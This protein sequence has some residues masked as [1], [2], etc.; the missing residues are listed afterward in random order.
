MEV[1]WKS[2]VE[3]CRTESDSREWLGDYRLGF[4]INGE[5]EWRV[6][7]MRPMHMQTD[8]RIHDVKHKIDDANLTPHLA[9]T[10]GDI[11]NQ[12]EC[13][14]KNVEDENQDTNYEEDEN[15]GIDSENDDGQQNSIIK[16]YGEEID[17]DE[18]MHGSDDEDQEDDVAF[19]FEEDDELN[20]IRRFQD[21]P[22][23]YQSKIEPE[24]TELVPHQISKE[25]GKCK[26]STYNP[27]VE[28][29]ELE[30]CMLYEDYRQFKKAMIDYAIHFKRDICYYKNES[31]RVMLKCT[32]GCPF[33]CTGYKYKCFS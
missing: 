29:Y 13:N 11:I 25:K 15:V 21:D 7:T 31:K 1:E 30:L 27:T 17:Y 33:H 6:E 16:Q 3:Q 28:S 14:D 20:D 18:N 9:L 32:K 8:L 24:E 22:P 19:L 2:S 10:D 12:S 26:H 5:N 4:R 23:S